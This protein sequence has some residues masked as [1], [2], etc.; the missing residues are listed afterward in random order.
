MS[1]QRIHYLLGVLVSL[2]ISLWV[3]ACFAADVDPSKVGARFRVEHVS[4]ESVSL[5]DPKQVSIAELEA[6]LETERQAYGETVSVDELHQIADAVTSYVRRKGYVFHTIYLPPQTVTHGA[7]YFALQ[8]GVLADVHVM[9]KTSMSSGLFERGFAGLLGKVVYGP[10]IEKQVQALRYQSGLNVFVFYSRGVNPGDVRLNLRVEPGRRHRVSLKVDNF[11]SKASG[12]TRAIGQWTAQNALGGFDHLS[13]ALMSAVDGESNAYG[14]L[15][16]SRATSGLRFVWDLSFSNNQFELGDRFANLGLEG[17]ATVAKAGL[18]Y[19]S[20]FKPGFRQQWRL[21]GFHK[22]NSLSDLAVTYDEQEYSQGLDLQWSKQTQ[23]PQQVLASTTSI[24]VTGGDMER[25]EGDGESF[26]KL[27]F[28]SRWSKG[29]G[30]GRL[31]NLFHFALGA[32]FADV[33]LPSLESYSLTGPYGVRGFAPGAFSADEALVA[34]LE[35]SLPSLMRNQSATWYLEPFIFWDWADGKKQAL[36]DNAVSKGKFSGAGGG[37]RFGLGKHISGQV[38]GTGQATSD[39]NGEES[40]G[41]QIWRFEL[42][43]Y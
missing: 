38:Y 20:D 22:T 19:V 32:Q 6:R 43:L 26:A 27:E 23:W 13:V 21:G 8:E 5:Q 12:E 39:I 14:S 28:N 1:T 25:S 34:S 35:W 40:D 11:G 24:T 29:F 4:L 9:N 36:A 37:F 16:Y 3:G 18:S 30:R 15:S 2:Q 41:E 7:V 17:D 33:N 10:N 31:Q 42:R